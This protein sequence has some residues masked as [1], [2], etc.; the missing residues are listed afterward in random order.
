MAEK[1]DAQSTKNDWKLKHSA[2]L[3]S[4]NFVCILMRRDI[5]GLK[6]DELEGRVR[7]ALMPL[8]QRLAD[9]VKKSIYSFKEEWQENV[10]LLVFSGGGATTPEL[11]EEM[12]KI[13]GLEVQVA[14][15]FAG[16]KMAA[17]I[18][19]DLGK[20]GPRFSVAFGLAGRRLLV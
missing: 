9:D 19:I 18:S 15:P 10:G 8:F 6:E 20:E 16:V 14:Q 5:S 1:N 4:S 2:V 7:K 12:T 13:L 3:T 17:P 11:A